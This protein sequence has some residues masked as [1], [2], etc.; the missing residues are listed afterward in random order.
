MLHRLSLLFLSGVLTLGTPTLYGSTPVQIDT[1]TASYDFYFDPEVP[2]SVDSDYVTIHDDFY[3][4]PWDAIMSS[5]ALPLSWGTRLN[6]T[7]EMVIKWDKPVYLALEMLSGTMRTCPAQNASD[8]PDGT[9]LVAPF[10]GCTQCYDFNATTNP[11]AASLQRAFALYAA[12]YAS[13]FLDRSPRGLLGV[14]IAAE[15]NL[16]GGRLCGEGWWEGVVEW[17]NGV[18]GVVRGY[19]DGRNLTTVPVFPSIQVEAL[20]GVQDGQACAGELEKSGAAGGASPTPALLTCIAQGVARVAPLHRDAFGVSTYPP[21]PAMIPGVGPQPWYLD[22]VI[23]ALP[24]KDAA[25]FLIAETG[26]NRVP[27]VVN[28][29]NGTVGE[30]SGGGSTVDPPPLDCQLLVDSSPAL[31]NAWLEY[32]V[33]EAARR[34][35]ALVTWWSDMD[36]LYDGAMS[37]CPCEAPPQYQSSCVFVSAFRE[38]VAAEGGAPVNG[39]V[40]AKAFGAMG[41]RGINGSTTL[42]WDTLQKA[43]GG[44]GAASL[45]QSM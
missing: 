11:T 17:H 27:L 6:A 44:R 7:L 28:L 30:N 39:E 15:V 4:V 9:P 29:G 37:S 10:S 34:G 14:N 25:T 22:A 20:M 40:E 38:I 21:P 42:L 13:A 24:P 26:W 19:L 45:K 2:L 3:G 35:W 8:A 43:R 31:A 1:V 5:S 33:A 12:F 16:E 32:L 36:L 18:Y 41:L 23:A